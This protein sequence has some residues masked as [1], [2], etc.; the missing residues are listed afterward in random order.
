MDLLLVGVEKS[1]D[2]KPGRRLHP[3]ARIRPVFE[4]FGLSNDA[5]EAGAGDRGTD[6]SVDSGRTDRLASAANED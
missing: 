2:A 4:P 3:G 6:C 5:N 1:E